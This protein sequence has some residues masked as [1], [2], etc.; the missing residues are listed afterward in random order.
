LKT[1][2]D[3]GFASNEPITVGSNLL[4]AKEMFYELLRRK[5]AGLDTDAVLLR[6][7][8][9]GERAEKKQTL[10]FNLIDF[11][12]ENSNI[13]AMMRTTAFP[14]SIIAQLIVRGVIQDR[15]VRT[16]EQCAPLDALLVELK[17]RG[18]NLTERW[19]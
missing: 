9:H 12:Q 2:L 5:L 19:H 10:S 8:I 3:L 6:V 16:P 4:T 11:Y 14:T 17:N 1:L 7:T 18:L 13:S 15:G